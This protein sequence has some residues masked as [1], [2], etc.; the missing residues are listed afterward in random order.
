MHQW[1]RFIVIALATLA[2]PGYA[3][4]AAQ[5]VLDGGVHVGPQFMQYRIK[6]PVD[7]EISELAVPLW[8]FMP[9][10][11][12]LSVDVGT[13]YAWSKVQPATTPSSTISGLTDTQLRASYTIG[14]KS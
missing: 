10:T 7:V 2:A 1:R 12:Q 4:V 11:K 5:A 14:R 9:I 6:S 3:P 8:A 13:A